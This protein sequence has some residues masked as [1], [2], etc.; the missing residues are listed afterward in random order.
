MKSEKG[1][2]L[3]EVIVSLALIGIMAVAF[4]SGL[5]T[6]CGVTAM[7]DERET[8]KNLAETQT[9]Y[10]KYHPYAAS[11]TPAPITGEFPGYAATIEVEPLQDSNIQKVIV[12]I[13]HKGRVMTKLESYKWR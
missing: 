11:Y 4:F 10:V 8:A 12:T 9:E 2:S 1:S 3:I 13:N 7:I 5:G 6:V